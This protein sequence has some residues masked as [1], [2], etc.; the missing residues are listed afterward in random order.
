MLP[1][2]WTLNSDAPKAVDS[3]ADGVAEAP[4]KIA[5]VALL[6]AVD[7]FGHAAREHDAGDAVQVAERLGEIE[8]LARLRDRGEQRVGQP[9]GQAI[10]IRRGDRRAELPFEPGGFGELGA[11]R[12]EPRDAAILDHDE[13]AADVDGCGLLHLAVHHDRE[14]GGAAADV[15]VDDAAILVVRA[16]RRA[17]AVG[18]EHRFHVVAGGGADEFAADLR[19]QLADRLRVLAAQ[20]LA[21]EDHR[22]GIDLIGMDAGAGVG[23][24]DDLADG[25]LVDA[26]IARV[27]R[28][29]DR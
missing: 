14:L 27:G 22:A 25:I 18:G 12:I 8:V 6:A 21:G 26:H 10:E 5:E 9:V 23:I 1:E 17:R 24:L 15:D 19:E 16:L 20:R 4:A 2:S 28:E 29:R 13:T 7:I 11:L 3:L